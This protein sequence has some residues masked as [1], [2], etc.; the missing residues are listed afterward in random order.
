MDE[1]IDPERSGTTSA[2]NLTSNGGNMAGNRFYVRIQGQVPSLGDAYISL[3]NFTVNA[4]VDPLSTTTITL[5]PDANGNV[6]WQEDFESQGYLHTATITNPTNLHWM[7]DQWLYI[8]SL[9]GQVNHV[10]L[11]Q[12]FNCGDLL[13][14][15]TA[16]IKYNYANK[17]SWNAYNTIGVSLDG[18]TILASDSTDNHSLATYCGPI[19]ATL[20]VPAGTQTFYIHYSM[21]SC[22]GA[23]P[24]RTNIVDNLEVTAVRK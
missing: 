23:D 16:S 5:T 4:Y 14:N 13:D 2:F 6:L 15:I 17:Q 20:S 8:T 9:K 7:P 24:K 12:Q 19:S 18:S 10:T 22:S 3:D 21:H 1:C 11:R